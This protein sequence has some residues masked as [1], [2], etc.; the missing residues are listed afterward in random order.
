MDTITGPG[1]SRCYVIRTEL[2]RQF[3]GMLG[4]PAGHRVSDQC[5][6]WMGNA[7]STI[8]QYMK[9]SQP[10]KQRQSRRWT[11]SLPTFRPFRQGNA[12]VHSQQPN[13]D[14]LLDATWSHFPSVGVMGSD[15]CAC[16][17]LDSEGTSG[18]GV[19]FSDAAIP[20]S[21]GRIRFGEKWVLEEIVSL[22]LSEA[23]CNRLRV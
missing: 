15:C 2:I 19:Q 5:E 3:Q 1:Y 9:L 23:R 11:V 4:P 6:T 17:A 13:L 12:T 14:N 10:P 20:N 7:K 8:C 21:F 16:C 18:C 22:L